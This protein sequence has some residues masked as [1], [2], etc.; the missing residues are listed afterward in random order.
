MEEI[1]INEQSEY[2]PDGTNSIQ[3]IAL[4]HIRKIGDICTQELT[5][6]YTDKKPVK[7]AGGIMF[8]EV[9]HP[10]L[11]EA[12]CNAVDF[13]L[14]LVTPWADET[15]KNK[16]GEQIEEEQDIL[17][18]LKIKRSIFR[19]ITK[20]FWRTNFFISTDTYNE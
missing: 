13:L 17:K 2:N 7:T 3:E 16:Y 4:R 10:D 12:Y 11:R 19:D 1:E 6:A 8:T 5:G 20:M 15:F 9:Y 18:K 14:D